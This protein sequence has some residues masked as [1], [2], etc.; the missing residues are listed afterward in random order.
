MMSKKLQLLL[1]TPNTALTTDHS[2]KYKLQLPTTQGPAHLRGV[3]DVKEAAV[4]LER[5]ALQLRLCRGALAAA[6]WG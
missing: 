3:N 4:A 5:L 2:T 1:T 6:H